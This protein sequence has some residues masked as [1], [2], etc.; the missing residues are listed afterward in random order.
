MFC[1]KLKPF[2]VH[3]KFI[4]PFQINLSNRHEPLAHL[5]NDNEVSDINYLHENVMKSLAQTAQK[6]RGVRLKTQNISLKETRK[7]MAKRRQIK[8]PKTRERIQFLN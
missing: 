4:Q 3:R 6:H 5:Q 8:H 1:T 2:N 7:L